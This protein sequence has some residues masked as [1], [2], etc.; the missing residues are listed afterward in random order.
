MEEQVQKTNAGQAL[1][2]AGFVLG[3]ITLII[4][5]IPCIGWI[6]LFPGAVAIILSIV[7]FNQ[8]NKA[9][10]NKGLIIAAI[11]I[12]ILGTGIAA[13]QA[14]FFGAI[15]NSALN[16]SGL[17]LS[18]LENVADEMKTA[19]EELED[20]GMDLDNLG[21][22]I[23][24]A[25]KGDLKDLESLIAEIEEGEVSDEIVDELVDQADSFLAK[26][27]EVAKK[28]KKGDLTAMVKYSAMSLRAANFMTKMAIIAPRMNEEQA[29]KFEDLE[30]KYKDDLDELN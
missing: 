28:V 26:Y 5:W 23:D 10:G 16:E 19:T 4:S 24:S 21:K 12:S 6:A 14:L 13:S 15:G 3:I 7:G 9:N 11:V 20:A 1:G 2:I 8:A 29:K 17:N 25:E 30:D 18:D 27:V 22:A